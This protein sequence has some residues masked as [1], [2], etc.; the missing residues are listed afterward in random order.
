M[1]E[2]ER[3]SDV[4]IALAV[5]SGS[6]A[7]GFPSTDSDYDVRFIYFHRREWYLSVDLEHKRDVIE[8]PIVPAPPGLPNPPRPPKPP[9][10]PKPRIP[11]PGKK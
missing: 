7:W 8:P 4:V 2:I 11:N 3:A 5:E 6:R 1:R 9:G 10:P